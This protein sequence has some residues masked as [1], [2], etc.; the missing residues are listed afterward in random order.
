[1]G[2]PFLLCAIGF[3][4]RR[5]K[6]RELAHAIFLP[7]NQTLTYTMQTITL[8]NTMLT[9]FLAIALTALSC[10]DSGKNPEPEPP[11]IDN[12]NNNGSAVDPKYL[13]SYDKRLQGLAKAIQ[14]VEGTSLHFGNEFWENLTWGR[15]ADA[16]LYVANEATLPQD[17]LNDNVVKDI[18]SAKPEDWEMRQLST[19]KAWAYTPKNQTAFG[20]RRVNPDYNTWR[21]LVLENATLPNSS[22]GPV[23]PGTLP[24][25]HNGALVALWLFKSDGSDSRRICGWYVLAR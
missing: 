2:V 9:F 15:F 20:V 8:K 22:T 21:W 13:G 3:D 14:S 18:L 23:L 5:Y 25:I 1:V 6:Q 24:V 7:R 12:G 19:G 11:D 17:Y 10:G 16:N 4:H